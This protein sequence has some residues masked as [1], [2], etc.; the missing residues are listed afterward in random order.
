MQAQIDEIVDGFRN[1][2]LERRHGGA[3]EFEAYRFL[4][5]TEKALIDQDWDLEKRI[6]VMRRFRSVIR[7]VYKPKD[8]R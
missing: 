6:V 8:Q 3:S 4:A 5:D 2:V 7:D 1:A